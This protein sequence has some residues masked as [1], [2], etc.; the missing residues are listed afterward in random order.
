MFVLATYLA[1]EILHILNMF[2]VLHQETKKFYEHGCGM[3]TR[4][5]DFKSLPA[6]LFDQPIHRVFLSADYGMRAQIFYL[7]KFLCRKL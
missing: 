7:V 6:Q 3:K 4:E 5:S 2:Q 1:E